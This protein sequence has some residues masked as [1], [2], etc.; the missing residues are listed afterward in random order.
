MF[1]RVL[2]YN[3]HKGIGGLD[4]RYRPERV[5]EV[6]AH[7]EPDIAFLQEVDD[8]VP[9]SGF[10]CQVDMFADALGFHHRA[11]Q[12]N[13]RL[14]V[15]HYG[16][17]IISRFPFT[18]LGDIDLSLPFKKRRQALVVS[19]DV[20]AAGHAIPVV[21]AN[22]HLG[23][24]GYERKMQL[25]RLLSHDY[26]QPAHDDVPIIIGGDFNDVWGRLGRRTLE[27]AGFAN[28]CGRIRTFPAA[29]PLRPLDRFYHRGPVTVDDVFA[30]HA[31]ICR[32]ASDH[33]PLIADFKLTNGKFQNRGLAP[34]G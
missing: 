33:L 23:L 13:V 8:G 4:R 27:P 28:A 17:A 7:Y 30:G 5:M 19:A 31:Q 11:Y 14:A 10:H 1:F 29:M 16:N 26:L 21:L 20:H 32:H 18:V 3:V 6:V 9:R 15:G 22:V 2:T 12:R 24:A 25:L 34:R